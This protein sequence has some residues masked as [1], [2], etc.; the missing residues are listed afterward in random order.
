ME[1]QKKI[2][3]S[4]EFLKL[5]KGERDRSLRNFPVFS[6]FIDINS[7]YLDTGQ[8][9]VGSP[10]VL[11]LHD[12]QVNNQ[13][14]VVN[15]LQA[16]NDNANNVSENVDED[17]GDKS[18]DISFDKSIEEKEENEQV[19]NNP[20]HY[21]PC[22]TPILSSTSDV[23]SDDDV[24][25]MDQEEQHTKNV[26]I[27]EGIETNEQTI[28]SIRCSSS[29]SDFVTCQS[30]REQINYRL[31][32]S[33]TDY[34]FPRYDFFMNNSEILDTSSRPKTSTFNVIE[35]SSEDSASIIPRENVKEPE[36]SPPDDN[37]NFF[38]CSNPNS[39]E[40]QKPIENE[41][42]IV[43]LISHVSYNEKLVRTPNNLD[44]SNKKVIYESQS[45]SSSTEE[46]SRN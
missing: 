33:E 35:S 29:S 12:S 3:S 28:K 41:K 25:E 19:D 17:T 15:D 36:I 27:N 24:N 6:R 26:I 20:H 45:E 4:D 2:F 8:N 16:G 14:D 21:V 37:V 13:N 18:S 34:R 38:L 46:S 43:E 9:I 5:V 30:E 40:N 32:Q 31:R 39:N 22:N 1:D 11:M 42:I 7:I 23:N 10:H 44:E